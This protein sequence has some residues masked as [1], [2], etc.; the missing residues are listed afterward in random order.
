MQDRY[1]G[2]VGDFGKLG[3]LRKIAGSGLTIG[4]NWYHTYKPEEHDRG[5]GKHIGYLH[6][7]SF[8][9]CDDELL[10][11]LQLIVKGNRGIASLEGARLISNACYYSEILRPGS[12]R[13]FSRKNWHSK[14]LENLAKADI[15]FCDP[16][17][18]L[19]VKSVPITGAKSDKYV[20]TAEL[21]D[22]YRAGKSVIFY[23]HRGREKKE[24]YLQRFT[25]LKNQ[26]ELATA[27]FSGLTFLRGS[28]RD[29][30]FLVQPF[31]FEKIREVIN[32][33]LQTNWS[34]HFTLLD[35]L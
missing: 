20:L 21:L 12:E 7:C 24:R 5:D 29:Y 34:R 17:N 8:R 11:A 16:D 18:G 26:R 32:C 31:H 9:G 23:N 15:V 14:S 25:P 6:D 35:G 13:T 4:V 33:L 3:L 28:L 30:I 1:A 22:Y 2:D 10:K 19:L 27:C